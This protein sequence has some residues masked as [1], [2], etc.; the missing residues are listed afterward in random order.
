MRLYH[1]A[2]AICC[3]LFGYIIGSMPNDNLTGHVDVKSSRQPSYKYDADSQM[4]GIDHIHPTNKS[5]IIEEIIPDTLQPIYQNIQFNVTR[6]MLRQSRPIIGNTQRLH[7]YLEKLRNKQCTTVLFL[8]GSGE[9]EHKYTC[10]L[11]TPGC[12]AY[13]ETL[14]QNSHRWA[15]C[16]RCKE[17]IY[18]VIHGLVK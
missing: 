9:F 7:A 13:N 8:G 3:G 10:N 12:S 14:C 1:L 15:Q 17:C 18:K 4:K 11:V 16:G 2:L 6:S 5:S